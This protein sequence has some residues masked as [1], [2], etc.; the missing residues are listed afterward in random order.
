MISQIQKTVQHNCDIADARY[1]SDFSLCIYL[2]KMR[3]YYRWEAG[4]S[5]SESLSKEDV[6]LWLS[7]K[8]A[9]W[10]LLENK[11]LQTVGINDTE[12]DPYDADLI[13]KELLK[14]NY[15]Y[16]S[17]LGLYSRPHFVLA[18]LLKRI[19][20]DEYTIYIC[21]TELA[22]DLPAPPAFSLNKN[23]FIR[24]DS[25]KRMIWEKIDEWRLQ[26]N[27]NT[28]L[29]RVFS[30]YD[31]NLDLDKALD[32]ITDL[33]IHSMTLHEIGEVHAASVVGEQWHEMLDSLPRSQANFMVRA[34]RDHIADC[35]STLPELIRRSD[36]QSLHFY[37]GNFSS[38][39]K[40]IFPG[41]MAAYN[42]AIEN[43]D[44]SALENMVSKGYKHWADL[45]QEIIFVWE[46]NEDQ[47]V[48]LIETLVKESY[49]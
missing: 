39:R 10:D 11:E 15:V 24:R 13:N 1:A 46:K 22:R 36:K 37:F 32:S 48:P 17:G 40:E 49:L 20:Q 41:L 28:A 12:Y 47:S 3:E 19:Q 29:E 6:G 21:G 7:D 31:L 35:Y 18:K 45:A 23:I 16:S 26:S 25:V 34:V 42:V 14:H 9:Q 27:H 2:L 30:Q 33:E 5:Y 43:S 38:I 4:K 8:E 44:Y